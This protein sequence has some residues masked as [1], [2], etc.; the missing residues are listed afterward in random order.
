MKPDCYKTVSA[1]F[2]LSP[3]Q[4]EHFTKNMFFP[5]SVRITRLFLFGY[6]GRDDGLREEIAPS[7][8][9]AEFAALC[10]ELRD[11]ALFTGK[12][13]RSEAQM[14]RAWDKINAAREAGK[15]VEDPKTDMKAKVTSRALVAPLFSDNSSV[16]DST[17]L[18]QKP[19]QRLRALGVLPLAYPGNKQDLYGIV[20]GAL[21]YLRS[22]IDCDIRTR[23]NYAEEVKY[24]A[25]MEALE[26][27]VKAGKTMKELEDTDPENKTK[28]GPLGIQRAVKKILRK[29]RGKKL[30]EA[31]ALEI[32]VRRQKARLLKLRPSAQ[33]TLPS[34]GRPAPY[35]LGDNFCGF[36]IELSGPQM[37]LDVKT[38]SLAGSYRLAFGASNPDALMRHLR[39][40]KQI[41]TTTKYVLHYLENGKRPRM[42]ELKEPRIIRRGSG[43]YLEMPVGIESKMDDCFRPGKEGSCAWNRNYPKD[44]NHKF[45]ELK[46]LGVDIGIDPVFAWAVLH[47][48]G[49]VK[50]V[51]TKVVVGATGKV[52]RTAGSDPTI[53]LRNDCE[54][55]KWMIKTAV[56]ARIYSDTVEKHLAKWDRPDNFRRAVQKFY[57]RFEDFEDEV[58]A[59]PLEKV[60]G[61]D[62]TAF[63]SARQWRNIGW[64]VGEHMRAL[65][66][67]YKALRQLRRTEPSNIGDNLQWQALLRRV[68]EMQTSWHTIGTKSTD[69]RSSRQSGLLRKLHGTKLRCQ[70]D[71]RKKYC[72]AII[73]TAIAQG[74]WLIVVEDL[75]REDDVDNYLWDLWSPASMLA[76]LTEMAKADGIGVVKVSPD[77]TSKTMYGTWLPVWRDERNRRRI[78][79]KDDSGAILDLDADINAAQNIGY[80]G[81]TRNSEPLYYWVKKQDGRVVP[82]GHDDDKDEDR[83]KRAKAL[84]GDFSGLQHL[85]VPE[86]ATRIYRYGNTWI[87]AQ[88]REDLQNEIQAAVRR[89]EAA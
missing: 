28:K 68:A 21:E 43:F 3:A 23:A 63:A 87:T 54:N 84:F 53:E 89:G 19:L 88:E 85:D 46:V 81:I 51:P 7:V 24:L 38:G 17:M 44:V 13:P 9:A 40:E 6:E 82:L 33:I 75:T 27:E 58:N 79:C 2:R 73:D 71:N 49:F 55:L 64:S 29:N 32:L 72:R 15:E 52:N 11:G 37:F 83:R 8:P 14:Q 35:R 65:L 22:Y 78:F 69:I 26:V 36:S 16:G 41:A 5:E 76:L 1:R 57:P 66:N 45:K 80:L 61:E 59:L 50:G 39:I 77:C 70:L 62:G 10:S 31:G 67:R 4:E 48:S 30:T 86:K 74:C 34:P 12:A 18:C 20:E 60:V 47:G 42:S 25:D 56:S